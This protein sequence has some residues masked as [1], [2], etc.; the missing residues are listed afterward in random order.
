MFSEKITHLK[1][2]G[3]NWNITELRFCGILFFKRTEEF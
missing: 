1:R 2:N 3:S